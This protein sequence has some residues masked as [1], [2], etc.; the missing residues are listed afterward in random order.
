MI[1]LAMALQTATLGATNYGVDAPMAA[2][3]T[4]PD[5]A[6]EF[7]GPRVDTTLWRY[8]TSRTAEGWANNEKQ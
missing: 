4:K 5:F 1:L 8:D 2:P 6:D 3:A 7:A